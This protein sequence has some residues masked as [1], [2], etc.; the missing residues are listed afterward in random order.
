MTWKLRARFRQLAWHLT[1]LPRSEWCGALSVFVRCCVE[2]A[3]IAALGWAR[4][5]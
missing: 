2:D 3:A 5:I 1:R 4:R